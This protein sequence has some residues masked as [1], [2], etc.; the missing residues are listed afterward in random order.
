[1]EVRP[2][3]ILHAGGLGCDVKISTGGER[4]VRWDLFHCLKHVVLAV[5]LL[6]SCAAARVTL[7]M[8]GDIED[9]LGDLQLSA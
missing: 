7:N 8:S 3:S 6:V 4:E 9:V 2:S 1:M 5:M